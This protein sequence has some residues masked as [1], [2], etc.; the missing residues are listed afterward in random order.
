M[1]PPVRDRRHRRRSPPELVFGFSPEGRRREEA[2]YLSLDGN[3]QIEELLE[4]DRMAEEQELLERDRLAEE[5]RIADLRRQRD[6]EQQRT[7]ALS[8]EQSTHNWADYVEAGARQ[9]ALKDVGHA[10]IRDADFYYQLVKWVSRLEA[11]ALEDHPAWKGPTRASNAPYRTSGKFE[12]RRRTPVPTFS[13]YRRWRSA[14]S[15]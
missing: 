4:H 11:E 14:S 3:A 5:Q 13:V 12:A 7:D 8:H 15:S 9:I 6:M 2:F 1:A 10:R